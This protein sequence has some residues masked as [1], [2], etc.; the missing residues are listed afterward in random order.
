MARGYAGVPKQSQRPAR[1]PAE[2]AEEAHA[3]QMRLK[4]EAAAR[5]RR[6]KAPAPA[7][8]RTA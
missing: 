4:Q 3:L 8:R 7:A 2:R 6:V 5:R 1:T